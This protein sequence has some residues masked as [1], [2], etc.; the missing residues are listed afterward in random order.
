M[1]YVIPANYQQ[2]LHFLLT[3]F[4][5]FQIYN[6]KSIENPMRLSIKTTK[7]RRPKTTC[8]T[9]PSPQTQTINIF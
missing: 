8:K 1:Y 4:L 3:H 6:H 7:T 9:I 5:K 2:N